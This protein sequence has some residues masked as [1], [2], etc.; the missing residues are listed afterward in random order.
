MKKE[1]PT[2]PAPEGTPAIMSFEKAREFARSLK[3][4]HPRDWFSYCQG[5]LKDRP[6]LPAGLPLHP[7]TVYADQGWESFE[8][9]I[10]LPAG[11]KRM[12]ILSHRAGL[13]AARTIGEDVIAEAAEAIGK[14]LTDELWEEI[15]KA[16]GE[17]PRRRVRRGRLPLKRRS[18]FAGLMVM[19]K[20]GL[21]PYRLLPGEIHGS[22]VV[23]R[24]HYLKWR[25]NRASWKEVRRILSQRV[26]ETE[27]YYWAILDRTAPGGR[28]PR[29]TSPKA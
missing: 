29:E 22:G 1:T 18:A 13:P 6:P 4:Q 16:L 5:K 23:C 10:G 28:I 24:Q 3:L 27:D 14:W 25:A 15:N 12:P 19:A 9:W 7:A 8:D 26:P 21:P 2:T 17:P 20:L 11:A